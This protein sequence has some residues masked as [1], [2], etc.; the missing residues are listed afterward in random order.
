MIGSLLPHCK[1]PWS[2]GG[3][4]NGGLLIAARG[5]SQGSGCSVPLSPCLGV[6]SSTMR[7]L[8]AFDEA[9]SPGETSEGRSTVDVP[10]PSLTTR[11]M[12]AGCSC[13]SQW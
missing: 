13:A 1:A 12:H 3:R 2:R 8:E 5:S 11:T 9:A 10:I 7:V 6:P 4:D